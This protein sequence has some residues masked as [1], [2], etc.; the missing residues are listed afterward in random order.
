M[1]FAV[2]HHIDQA[3]FFMQ[4]GIYTDHTAT[5]NVLELF[6]KEFQILRN[7]TGN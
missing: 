4:A 2:Y 1:V 3:S 6:L 7:T 5:K